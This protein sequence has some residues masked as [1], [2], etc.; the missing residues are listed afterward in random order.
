MPEM[1]GRELAVAGK[2]LSHNP[3]LNRLFMTG[4]T[5]KVSLITACWT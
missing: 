1:N 5:A 2:L 4:Y 3:D